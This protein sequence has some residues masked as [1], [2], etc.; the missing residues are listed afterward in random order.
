M[1]ITA[2]GETAP[3]TSD[4]DDWFLK[5]LINK[6]NVFILM[7]VWTACHECLLSWVRCLSPENVERKNH[8]RV[9]DNHQDTQR[10]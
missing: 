5:V 9:N 8:A 10:F 4:G 6:E 7:D 1:L 2:K 3:L